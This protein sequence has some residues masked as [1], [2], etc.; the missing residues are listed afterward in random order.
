MRRSEGTDRGVLTSSKAAD[1]V[2]MQV[3]ASVRI[4]EPM[5]EVLLEGAVAPSEF[6]L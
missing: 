2:I 6:S 1:E 4:D 5:M 3:I